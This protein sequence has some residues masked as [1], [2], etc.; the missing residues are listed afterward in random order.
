[1]LDKSKILRFSHENGGERYVK[2]FDAW[3][4]L[5]IMLYAVIRRFDSTTISLFS[6]L[7]FKGVGRH[8]K[9][10]KKKKGG[11]LAMNRAYADY[12]KFEELTRNGVTYVTKMKKNLVYRTLDDRMYINAEGQMVYREQRVV[13]SKHVRKG[14]D[15]T[16]QADEAEL[17]AEVLLR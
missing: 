6:D 3:Q 11:I 2:H 12:A 1:M 9:T 5:V 7:I 8:P 15:A 16:L 10:G 14:E 13:F 4:H 17:P